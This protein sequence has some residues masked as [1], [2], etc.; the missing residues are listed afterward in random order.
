[1]EIEVTKKGD[2]SILQISGDVDLYSSP[3]VREHIVN[4]IDRKSPNLLV[5]LADVTYMDSSGVATLVE[6]LQLTNKKGGR[7]KLYN[8][9]N[10]IRDVFELSR[11][12]KVFDICDSEA[13]ALE[14]LAR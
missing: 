14:G 3:Q 10:A 11:L 1:M 2:F 6:A 12:D 9:G 8:L 5:N 4:L 7:L 13:T